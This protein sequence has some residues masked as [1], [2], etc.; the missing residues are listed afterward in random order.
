MDIKQLQNDHATLY[1]IAR[2]YRDQAQKE[3]QTDL[4]RWLMSYWIEFA[5]EAARVSKQAR[6]LY[7]ESQTFCR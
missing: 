3:T 4:R 1:A 7:D 6:D 2:T 5:E